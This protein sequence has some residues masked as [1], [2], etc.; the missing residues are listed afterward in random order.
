MRTKQQIHLMVMRAVSGAFLFLVAFLALFGVG[1]APTV[2]AQE[3]PTPAPE[4][5]PTEEAPLDLPQGSPETS[6]ALCEINPNTAYVGIRSGSASGL[7]EFDTQ[8]NTIRQS[9]LSWP[10]TPLVSALTPDG[11]RLFMVGRARTRVYGLD[12]TT[13]QVTSIPYTGDD[14]RGLVI[15]KDG[16]RMYIGDNSYRKITVIDLK[17]NLVIATIPLNNH[18]EQ[19]ALSPDDSRLYVSANTIVGDL[20]VIDTATN[21]VI[22]NVIHDNGANFGGV[23][24]SPDGK[25]VFVANRSAPPKI[26]VFNASNLKLI[27]SISIPLAGAYSLIGNQDGSKLYVL[28]YQMNNVVVVNT[29]TLTYMKTIPLGYSQKGAALTRDGIHMYITAGKNVHVVDTRTDTVSQVIPLPDTGYSVAAISSLPNL[30]IQNGGFNGY[31]SNTAMIPRY[32]QAGGFA[33]TD[34]KYTAA[35]Q[36]GT[37]SVKIDG[38][39]GVSKNLYQVLPIIGVA[40][41]SYTFSYWVKGTAIPADANF[42]RGQVF[43]YNDST[44]VTAQTIDCPIHTYADF[45]K[46]TLTFTVPNDYNKV[47][48]RFTYSK[49][50]GRVWFDMVSL[51]K[52]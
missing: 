28:S 13:Y 25:T 32:W 15:S 40:G 46:K 42:C 47:I 16:S 33:P 34:G 20:V 35:V 52:K 36:E 26:M 14:Q 17:K 39:S 4:V 7:I 31:P 21:T 5:L 19:I 18:P 45:E 1:S 29:K 49:P 22:N 48:V 23:Y 41:D 8:T 11:K 50:T 12:T 9:G 38:A 2:R 3:Q 37:A 27:K 43:V 24:V 51:V 30:L 6:C 10:G 44:L